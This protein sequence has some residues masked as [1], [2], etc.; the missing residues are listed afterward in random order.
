MKIITVPF[1]LITL[2]ASQVYGSALI[3]GDS[4]WIETSAGCKVYN[5]FPTKNE[6]V[7]WSGECIGGIASG[8]G[9]LIWSLKGAVAQKYTGSMKRGMPSGY[10][11]Y[12]LM[13][14]FLD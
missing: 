2:I 3:Q 6:S 10:G 11:I 1:L 14:E 4:V 7:T 13:N 9:V 12:D 8:E 5:P